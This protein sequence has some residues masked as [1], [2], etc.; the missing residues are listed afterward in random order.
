MPHLLVAVI[1]GLA[2]C[3]LGLLLTTLYLHRAVTHRAVSL[4]PGFAFVL[5][6]L[7]WLVTGIKPREW[8]A[9][10]RRHHA[11]TDVPGDPHSPILDGYW[12][13]QLFNAVLY[14]RAAHDPETLRKYSR[15]IK[16][17]KWDRALFDHGFL[18]LAVAAA[19]VHVVSYLVL[20]AAINAIGHRFGKR[21][22]PGFATNNQWLAL[23]TWGEGF[24]SNHHAAPTSAR[25]SFRR[26]QL[27]PGWWVVQLCQRLHWLQ[28]R[29]DGIHFTRAAQAALERQTGAHLPGAAAPAAGKPSPDV[30]AGEGTVP[31]EVLSRVLGVPAGEERLPETPPTEDRKPQLV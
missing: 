24:H 6:V 29:H 9:V 18:G 22:F 21:P 15:D 16:V 7:V 27:D 17:D 20:N 23:L 2:V 4:A 14:R 26:G 10:H 3:Q 31:E 19:G 25:L 1:V 8:A 13:V 11:Y 28:V 5:R 30:P 12:K